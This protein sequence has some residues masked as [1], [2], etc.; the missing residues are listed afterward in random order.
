MKP[1]ALLLLLPAL[2]SAA[3]A[4]PDWPQFRGP[5]RDGLSPDTGL[6]KK[7]PAAGPAVVWKSDDVGFGFSSVAIQ[8]DTVVTMGDLGKDGCHLIAVSRAAGKKRWQYRVGDGGG[9]GGYPGPRSTPSIDGDLVFGLGQYGVL[10]AV[11]L[12]TGAE[13]WRTNLAKDHGGQ[14]GGWGYAESV[15]I[16]GDHLICTPGGS[17]ATVL[18]VNK[19]DGT[20]VWKGVVKGGAPAGY[21]S[22]VVSFAAGVKQYVTLLGD[23]LVGFAAKDGALLWRY[24]DTKDR[25]HGN[26]ANI[27]SPVVSGDQLFVTA[28]YDR[29]A[30]LLTLFGRGGAVGVKEEYWTDKLRNK[31][32]GV[33]QV[34]DYLYGDLDDTGKIWCAAAKTGQIAW[35]RGDKLDAGGSA[36]MTY[37]DGLLFV[38]YQNG[39]VTLV[40]ADPTKYALLSSFRVPNGRGNSWAHPVVI[41]GKMYVREKETVWCYDVADK[42]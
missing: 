11:S 16:D 15:L 30:A 25:F 39:W 18:C 4:E 1:T 10:V 31:H 23:S 41:G 19:N 2:L 35:T 29:G 20:A 40:D 12:T 33:I 21:S 3:G 9:G 13:V 24:G 28:G 22:V 26:T 32:G 37:A 36:S 6:L 17:T 8:G 38:R 7:W 34:G 5:K 27:P 14:P 42:K